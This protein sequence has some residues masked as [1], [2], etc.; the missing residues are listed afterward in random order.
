M[1]EDKNGT[2][3]I[4]GRWFYHNSEPNMQV[5]RIRHEPNYN[6]E[7]EEDDS[8]SYASCE[9]S[10]DSNWRT[11]GGWYFHSLEIF[12]SD[13]RG[14]Y[15][16]AD[17]AGKLNVHF[18]S[19]LQ[20]QDSTKESITDDPLSFADEELDRESIL[21]KT[22]EFIDD[23]VA[24]TNLDV[25]SNFFCSK[26]YNRKKNELYALS[27]TYIEKFLQQ[28]D[29][30][31]ICNR[32]MVPTLSASYPEDH[33]S[34]LSVLDVFSGCGGLS[35]GLEHAGMEIKWAVDINPDALATMRSAHPN[36]EVGNSFVVWYCKSTTTLMFH[37]YCQLFCMMAEQFLEGI[38][39]RMEG[40]PRPGE[41]DVLCGGPPCQGFSSNNPFRS[42]DD[43]RNK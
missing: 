37:F 21:S 4:Q 1:R 8:Y 18:F 5:L 41:V 2:K 9:D 25:T 24:R 20:D 29:V 22:Y 27:R 13:E 7:S 31:L 28:K 3:L 40:Y 43:S 30:Q 11:R 35:L 38:G 34:K 14:R 19:V 32:N 39:R 10:K 17:L 36:A 33:K 6:S 26:I 23:I 16:V 15:P 12:L 42:V